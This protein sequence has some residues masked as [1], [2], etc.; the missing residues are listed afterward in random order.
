MRIPTLCTFLLALAIAAGV[1]AKWA[2]AQETFAPLITENTALFVHVDFRKV[3]IEAFKESWTKYADELIKKLRFDAT[4]QRATMSALTKDL[5]K[6]DAFI[7]PTFETITQE[8]GVRELA[9]I[10]ETKVDDE[11]ILMIAVPWKGKT[12]GDQ[13]TLTSLLAEGNIV[14]EEMGYALVPIGDFLFLVDDEELL[15]EWL[16]N[17]TPAENGTIMQAMKTLGDDEIKIALSMTDALRKNLLEEF[18]VFS[19][20]PEPVVNILTHV[21]RKV[22]WAAISFPNPLMADEKPPIKLTVKAS[23]AADARQLR[24]LLES[25]IDMAIT[26][27]QGYMAITQAMMRDFGSD[28]PDVPEVVYA[29]AKGYLRTMLPV[30]EGEMMVFQA[31]ETDPIVEIL[32]KTQVYSAFAMVAPRIIFQWNRS[33]P[34][35]Q[36]SC[37]NNLK[38]IGLAIHNYHDVFN[39]L[40]PLYT[41]DA[42]GKPLHSWRVLILPFIEQAALYDAIRFDEPWDSEYNKQFHSRVIP[43]YVCPRNATE[44]DN[45]CHYSAI[46]GGD[47]P[48]SGGTFR[49]TLRAGERGRDSFSRIAD[50]TSNTLAVVEVKEAFNWMDPTADITLEEFMKGI[51]ADGRAGSNHPGGANAVWFD[52]STSLLSDNLSAEV[53]RIMAMPDSGQGVS[54]DG[55]RW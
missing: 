31:P 51:N 35:Q 32:L 26:A 34:N 50:G 55:Q 47:T 8:L 7:R 4:S 23:T 41:V 3:E 14:P 2:H 53:L 39:A 33:F 11:S 21:A 19:D 54:R 48:R 49:P 27:W 17:V 43:Q 44:G 52:G 16:E 29:L 12:L 30:V 18:I 45:N 40:P 9:F 5:E 38:Q 1:P 36:T 24:M 22:D 15:R 10:V 28:M 20:F 42:D 6:L 37:Q 46:V 13:Q 25:G